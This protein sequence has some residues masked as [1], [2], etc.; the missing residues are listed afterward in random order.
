[1]VISSIEHNYNVIQ[2]IRSDIKTDTYK[3]SE[4]TEDQLK[5]Y[6]IIKFKKIKTKPELVH[7][8]TLLLSLNEFQDLVECFQKVDEFYVVFY[9]AKGELLKAKLEQEECDLMERLKIG[10]RIIKKMVLQNMPYYF[11]CEGLKEKNVTITKNLEVG[12]HY[13]LSDVAKYY[14]YSM[15]DVCKKLDVWIQKLFRFEI[16]NETSEELMTFTKALKTAGFH[17]YLEIY[18]SYMELCKKSNQ[19]LESGVSPAP[20]SLLF[21]CWKRI[22][23]FFR[24]MID[25]I[26]AASLVLLILLSIV[27]FII[28]GRE[29]KVPG[30]GLE[31]IGTVEIGGQGEE[32]NE[33]SK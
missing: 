29:A 18:E 15:E 30:E 20:N 25:Y 26:A 10:E 7:Y 31:H 33:I 2:K 3:C 9:Y 24:K 13:E 5:E 28:K 17:T 12:F 23:E 16:K 22:K 6:R 11:L 32:A 4:Y 21:R 14:K 27:Y 8:F 1:M 19:L